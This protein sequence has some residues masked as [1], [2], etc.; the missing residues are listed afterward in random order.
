ML[1]H[2]AQMI[3]VNSRV[4]SYMQTPAHQYCAHSINKTPLQ[5]KQA[6]EKVELGRYDA[7]TTYLSLAPLFHVAGLNSSIAVTLAG[8]THVF[9]QPPGGPRGAWSRPSLCEYGWFTVACDTQTNANRP[10]T[11]NTTGLGPPPLA[12]AA[13][14][15]HGVNTLVLVPAMLS[16]LLDACDAAESAAAAQAA[17]VRASVRFVLVGGQPLTEPLWRRYVRLWEGEGVYIAWYL[18]SVVDHLTTPHIRKQK[19]TGPPRRCPTRGSC[20]AT[21]APRPAPASPS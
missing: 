19:Q 4:P 10:S 13:A 16:A 17:A 18:I 20:R 14:A 2:K 5:N 7:S 11:D 6:Q 3:Q 1:S 9:L 15:V 8:G 12:L 21:R